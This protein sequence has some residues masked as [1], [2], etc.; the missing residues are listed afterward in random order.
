MIGILNLCAEA[1]QHNDLF[2]GNRDEI[3]R[4]VKKTLAYMHARYLLMEAVG[5]SSFREILREVGNKDEF[6]KWLW[7]MLN[8]IYD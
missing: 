1:T 3:K 7:K 5:N 8:C 2:H 6:P 4:R